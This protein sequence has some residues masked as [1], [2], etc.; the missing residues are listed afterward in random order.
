MKALGGKRES[1]SISVSLQYPTA[2]GKVPGNVLVI[3]TM[4]STLPI[5]ATFELLT[6]ANMPCS[7]YC[8]I[9]IYPRQVYMARVAAVPAGLN[10]PP[11]AGASSEYLWVYLPFQM[12]CQRNLCSFYFLTS[13]K[14]SLKSGSC[15]IQI[16]SPLENTSPG[17]TYSGFHLF[18][19]CM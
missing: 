5:M 15:T 9:Q 11:K 6:R 17:G 10:K 7:S 8:V 13:S 2:W 12:V 4:D 18:P 3:L 14:D 1:S 16:S 19:P